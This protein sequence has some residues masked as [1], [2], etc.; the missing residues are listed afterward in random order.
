MEKDILCKYWWKEY[1]SGYLILGKIKFR[2][3]NII[4][5]YFLVEELVY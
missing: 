5:R 3:K 1:W 2:I 4:K